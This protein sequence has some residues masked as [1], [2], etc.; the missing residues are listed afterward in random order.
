LNSHEDVDHEKAWKD[1]GY[2]SAPERRKPDTGRPPLETALL[3][4]GASVAAFIGTRA[5]VAKTA[6]AAAPETPAPAPRSSSVALEEA[7]AAP[8]DPMTDARAESHLF[9]PAG[10][11]AP[12]VKPVIDPAALAASVV[13]PTAPAWASAVPSQEWSWPADL[14]HVGGS[15]IPA[16]KTVR[17]L[18]GWFPENPAGRRALFEI[19]GEDGPG[20]RCYENECAGAAAALLPNPAGAVAGARRMGGP[21]RPPMINVSAGESVLKEI[22]ARELDALVKQR[23]AAKG[24]GFLTAAGMPMATLTFADGHQ[25]TVAYDPLVF[26]LRGHGVKTSAKKVLFDLYGYGKTDK[27]QG[28]NDI[29]ENTGVLVFDASGS[30]RSGKDGR[31]VLGDRTSLNGGLPDGFADGFAA[32][33]GLVDKGI[34]ERVLSADVAETGVLEADSLR[35]LEKA[36]G[37]KM[38]VGGMHGRT[39]SL[40][41]A[42]VRGIALSQKPAEMINDFDGRHNGL[43]VQPGAVFLRAD[44]TVGSYMNIWLA[45]KVGELGLERVSLR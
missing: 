20:A 16:A 33:K 19:K 40:A 8:A 5:L 35:A 15:M 45:A 24:E 44:G 7:P 18:V 34:R 22:R 29:D 27:I 10:S 13:S 36:Y 17:R 11:P 25:E 39:I 42:G 4:I 3:V 31:E 23:G 12:A 1:P 41:E 26:D 30:G 32:L 28:M 37:L 6:P 38:R 14:R 9:L 43:K 2:T 21:G